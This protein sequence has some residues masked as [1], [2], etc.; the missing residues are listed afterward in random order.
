MVL[1][2]T[3]HWN[4]CKRRKERSGIVGGGA[5]NIKCAQNDSTNNVTD[6]ASAKT[7][8]GERFI[9]HHTIRDINCTGSTDAGRRQCSACVQSRRALLKRCTQTAQLHTKPLDE[10]T[11]HLV[12]ERNPSLMREKV[13]MQHNKLKK[14]RDSYRHKLFKKLSSIR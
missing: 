9:Y 2:Y 8:D 1:L 14:K 7:T 13:D 4:C 6:F 11:T 3:H 10:S 12:L 5:S